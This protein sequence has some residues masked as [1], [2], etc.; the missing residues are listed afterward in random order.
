M[1]VKFRLREIKNLVAEIVYQEAFVIR[2]M[3]T[4]TSFLVVTQFCV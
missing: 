4:I 2:S 1:K 3:L